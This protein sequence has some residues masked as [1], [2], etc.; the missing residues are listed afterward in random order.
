MDQMLGLLN[1]PDKSGLNILVTGSKGKGSVSRLLE[2]ILRAHGIK[3]GLFTSPHLHDYNERI[4]VNG[5]MISNEDLVHVAKTVK[6]IS[7]RLSANLPSGKYISPMA[8]GLAMGLLHFKSVQTEMN[9]LECGRG[10]RFDD[11]AQAHSEFAVINVIFDEHLPYLGESL[12]DVAWHKAGVINTSQRGVFV[13][14]QSELVKRILDEEAQIKGVT[15]TYTDKMV[16]ELESYIEADYN[17]ANASLAY[18]AAC[19][20]LG[21]RFNKNIAIQVIK[22]FTFSGC[23]EKVSN[24]PDI[25]IDGCIHPVCAEQIVNDIRQRDS[26]PRF[27]VGIP[28]NKAYMKVVEAFAEIAEWVILTEPTNCH[29]PFSGEQAEYSKEMSKRGFNVSHNTDLK[30]AIDQALNELPVDGQIY[31]VGTQIYLG[32]IKTELKSRGLI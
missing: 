8:N 30:S 15:I 29:L 22:E 13:A 23:L 28:D 2:T 10:A 18:D 1:S 11:V 4:R 26:R 14:E 7:E 17:L 32:Q 21:L 16:A 19:G 3:T 20:I 31:I 25:F 9:I 12:E 5:E 24:A 6:P 27:L